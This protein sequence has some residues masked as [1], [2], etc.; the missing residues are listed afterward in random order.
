LK[1]RYLQIFTIRNMH[2]QWYTN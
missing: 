2:R 1:I